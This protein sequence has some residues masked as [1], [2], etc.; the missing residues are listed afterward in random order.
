MYPL[1]YLIIIGCLKAVITGIANTVTIRISLARITNY[2][3]IIAGYHTWKQN[4]RKEDF[5]LR[6]RTLIIW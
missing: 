5:L 3:T 6:I 2:W 4:K 1:D